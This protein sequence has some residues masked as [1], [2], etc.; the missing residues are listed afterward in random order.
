MAKITLINSDVEKLVIAL[1]AL[2]KPYKWVLLRQACESRKKRRGVQVG[3]TVALSRR[4]WRQ[5][6]AGCAQPVLEAGSGWL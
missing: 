1:R 2:D 4:G 6:R 5:G 3:P